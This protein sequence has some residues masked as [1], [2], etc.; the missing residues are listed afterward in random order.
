MLLSISVIMENG[1]FCSRLAAQ[2]TIWSS[3]PK[4]F[5]LNFFWGVLRAKRKGWASDNSK[6]FT[7]AKRLVEWVLEAEINKTDATCSMLYK[8]IEM[9]K[10]SQFCK[11]Y[12][13]LPCFYLVIQKIEK[14]I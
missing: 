10:R 5:F 1:T 9:Q 4:I 3:R 6:V 8:K 12:P 2:D 11:E 14:S 7:T 13:A